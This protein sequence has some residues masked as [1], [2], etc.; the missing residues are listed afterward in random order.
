VLFR[1]VPVQAAVQ[2]LVSP[3]PRDGHARPVHKR[4]AN[5]T[6]KPYLS[7]VEESASD[8]FRARIVHAGAHLEYAEAL[9]TIA[10]QERH[11]RGQSGVSVCVR[12][13][14]SRTELAWE[15]TEPADLI[16]FTGHGAQD[17]S[18][19]EGSPDIGVE[20]GLIEAVAGRPIAANG[21]V[22]D[23]CYTW[24]L[25][26]VIGRQAD[27]ELAY[28]APDGP[29]P[30]SHTWLV[31]GRAASASRARGYLPG[32]RQLSS[33]GASKKRVTSPK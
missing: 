16:V 28:L 2:T 23:A 25:R 11:Q 15:L 29:A 9:A 26:S 32:R 5:A 30:Y 24:Q 7:G 4:R 12:A 19:I 6:R 1:G 8:T 33:W 3:G 31:T 27:R 20:P 18:W 21:L 13:A 22:M 14:G 17:G 10:G